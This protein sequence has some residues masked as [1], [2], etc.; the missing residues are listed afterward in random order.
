LNGLIDSLSV[1]AIIDPEWMTPARQ[2]MLTERMISRLCT[3]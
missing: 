3:P 2:L 1:E